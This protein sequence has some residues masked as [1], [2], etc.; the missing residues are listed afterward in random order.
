MS[1]PYDTTLK[2]LLADFAADWVNW[3]APELGLPADTRVTP[4]DPELST[5]QLAADKVFRLEPPANGL[6]HIEFQ[7]TWDGKLPERLHTYNTM[8]HDRYNEAVYSIAVL[9]RRDANTPNMTGTFRRQYP[10]GQEYLRFNYSVLRVWK[11]SAEE[12]LHGGLGATPLALLT[13]EAEGHLG[14]FVDRMQDR[15]RAE[16]VEKATRLMLLTS[17]YILLGMRYN[18]EVTAAA[19]S[20]VYDMEESSTYQLILRKGE[21]KGRQEGR[22]EGRI[23]A[24]RESLMGYLE[25]KFIAVPTTLEDEIFACEDAARLQAA[26]HLAWGISSLGEFHL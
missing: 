23:T 4:F 11:L 14:E 9:L 1:K 6:L 16:H 7:S 10:D 15:F 21:Q 3:I 5:V 18:N 13:D 26:T 20:G 2:Q 17:G 8:L 25:K 19:Y 22:Q 12:L 24:L